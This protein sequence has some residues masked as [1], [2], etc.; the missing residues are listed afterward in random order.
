MNGRQ[1][2]YPAKLARALVVLSDSGQ[3]P[4]RF[5]AGEDA[6]AGVEQSLATIQN[7]IDAHRR[8]SSTPSYED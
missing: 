5:I 6:V 1:G 3:L 4:L 8:L 7:Q 2:G